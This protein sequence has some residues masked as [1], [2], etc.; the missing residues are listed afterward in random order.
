MIDNAE[1]LVFRPP[2]EARSF[3]L[4]ITIGCSHNTCTFCPMYKESRFRIRPLEEIDDIIDSAAAAYP[5]TRRVFLADGDALIVRTDQLLHIIK[6]CYDAFPKLTRIGAYATP[7]DINRKSLEELTALHQAGLKIL[8]TGIESGDDEVLRRV[9]KG[10]TAA[11]VTAAGQKA[12]AAG[13]KLSAMIL[14]G[15]GGKELS[16]QHALHTADVVNAMKPTM[17]SALTLIIPQTVP[18]YEQVLA[19]TFTPLT[20]RGFLQELDL[21][22]RHIDIDTPCIFRSN[23]VSNL[24]PINGTLPMDKPRMLEQLAYVIPYEDDKIPLLNDTGNF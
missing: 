19:G 22:L 24:Y 16:Q 9:D 20:A 4:R 13:M 7:G 11:E 12:L 2:S 8:Y 5:F 10:N 14:L 15:L 6:H 1:G 21:I 18:L 3:I 23:H 17:L